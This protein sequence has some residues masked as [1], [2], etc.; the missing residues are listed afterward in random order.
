MTI[1]WILIT[2]VLIAAIYRANKSRKN[3]NFSEIWIDSVLI[4]ILANLLFLL[5]GYLYREE[6]YN[7]FQGSRLTLSQTK[8]TPLD[9]GRKYLYD[10]QIDLKNDREKELSDYKFV[11]SSS[12]QYSN[13]NFDSCTPMDIVPTDVGLI[14]VETKAVGL[15][16]CKYKISLG[17]YK[18]MKIRLKINGDQNEPDPEILQ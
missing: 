6:I 7:Q 5:V 16:D 2:A 4:A 13:F 3:K 14:S 9:N 18:N 11:L 8:C 17:S 15:S 1:L 12:A 10:C